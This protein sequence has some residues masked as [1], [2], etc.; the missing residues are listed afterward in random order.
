MARKNLLAGLDGRR[1]AG[2]QLAELSR[3][4]TAKQSAR[5][6]SWRHGDAGAI[7]AVTRS[8]EQLKAH[9]IVE[10]AP[11][12]IEASFIAD[13]LETSPE[14]HQSLGD[15]IRE[16][17]QQVPMLVRPHP[18]REGRYQIAYGRRRLRAVAELGRSRSRDGQAAD[19]RAARRGAR[20]GK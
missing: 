17:G 8:I 19:R 9:S 12:L 7:G 18:H 3:P 2:R 5:A 16:H 20:P 10:I 15:S 11:D 1:V 14:S 4:A 13:R 6:A